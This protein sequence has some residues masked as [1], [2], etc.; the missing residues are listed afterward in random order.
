M[1]DDST[2]TQLALL[3]QWKAQVEIHMTNTDIN[4]AA[5]QEERNHALK[6][7]I[8]VLGSAVISMVAWII[9]FFAGH[10]K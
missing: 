2:E 9:N 10:L 7:G 6:W 4:V 5:L 8:I 3:K 1:A